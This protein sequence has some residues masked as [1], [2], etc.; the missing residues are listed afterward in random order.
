MKS[1]MKGIY[2]HIPFCLKKCAYCDFNSFSAADSLK[3]EY[4]RALCREMS[5][6][7]GVEADSVYIGG[8]TPTVLK[9]RLLADVIENIGKF[10][11]L[12]R[13]TEFTVEMNPKTADIEKLETMR[14]MGV[15][16]LSV[17]VQSFRDNEL[18]ALGR[19]HTAADAKEAIAL[20]RK[21]GFENISIDLMSAIPYQTEESFAE[22]LKTAISEEVDHISC[23]SLILEEGTPLFDSVKNGEITLCDEDTERNIY[24]YAVDTL[25]KNGYKQYEISNF[26]K[27]GKRSRHNL[28][29]WKAEE[30]I[31]IGLSAHSYSG[32]VRF[33]NTGSIDEYIRGGK[34]EI[35]ELTEKDKM[36][37][38]M[39]LGLRMTEGVEK[40]DFSE[41]F[42]RDIYEVFKDPLDKFTKT[43]F[44]I[45]EGGR[46]RLS[47]G[48]VSVSNRIMCEF[49]L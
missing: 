43:G 36:S 40:S 30:Y 17:G 33:S 8:G 29:Y 16:R 2:V 18:R 4:V 1:T 26:A 21:A 46:I 10:F 44:L 39:F 38:F 9:T 48:A 32:N 42:G 37:E 13:D 14:R 47:Q 22:S 6:Y 45:D 35:T 19:V 24:E 49:L 25:E 11:S 23:Y 34:R 27:N 3:E 41:R 28:K 31:G 5:E 20:A 7:K 12:C 15:N